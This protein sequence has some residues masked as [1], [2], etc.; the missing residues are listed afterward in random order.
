MKRSGDLWQIVGVKDEQL[1]TKIAQ[2]VGQEIIAVATK[3]SV[4]KAGET[5]GVKNLQDLLKKA[6]DIL[7]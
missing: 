4:T 5:L 7:K 1:A 6:N 3:G 2:K